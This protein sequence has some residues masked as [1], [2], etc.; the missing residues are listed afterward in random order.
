VRDP[1]RAGDRHEARHEAAVEALGGTPEGI[2]R[3]PTSPLRR[4]VPRSVARRVE[5]FDAAADAAF[6]HLRGRPAADR[7]FYS[8]SALGDFSLIWHLIGTARALT[9][10]RRVAEAVRLTAALGVETVLVNVLIKSLFRRSRPAWD[11]HRPHNLRRP[12]SSS[13]PSGHATSGFLSARLLSHDDPAW[14]LYYAIA[15]VVASSRVHVRIHHASDVVAGAAIGLA[16]G[17]I[18]RRVAPLPRG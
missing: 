8:A 13:F 16:L 3:P 6:D 15:V 7:L 2:R 5:Q 4:V 9:A 17:E 12:L 18:A 14:P 1:H 11:Q 10:E